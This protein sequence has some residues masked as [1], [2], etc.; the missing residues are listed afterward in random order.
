[1]SQAEDLLNSLT[2][3]SEEE[4]IIIGS[5]RAIKVP[6]SLKKIAVQFDNNVRTVTF[7]C[8]RY[9]DGRDLS[10]MV[11]CINYLLPNG[12]PGIYIVDAV[13]VDE[14]DNT[15]MHF[16]WIIE[17][18][19]TKVNGTLSFLVCAKKTKSD[20]TN[21]NHW[22]TE[23]NQEMTISKG[24]NCGEQIVDQNPD[25]I[26]HILLRLDTIES[27]PGLGFNATEAKENQVLMADGNGNWEWKDPETTE[28]ET[29]TIEEIL[30][31]TP[32]NK[33]QGTENS[34]K[35]AGINESGDI[36]PMIPAGV[37]YNEETKCLEYGEDPDAPLM[38]GIKLDGTLSK[39]GY[40]ADSKKV[41]DKFSEIE[42]K[43]TSK[44]TT[45]E[46]P[47]VGKI[48][49][50]KSVNKDGSFVCEWTD[51]ARELN[52]QIN[53]ESIVKDGI[54]EIPFAG[55]DNPGVTSIWAGYGLDL[56]SKKLL[57]A[58]I[59]EEMIRNRDS[60]SLEAV[61]LANLDYAVK[62]AMT[63]GKGDP[64]TAD[65]QAAA[66]E[67]ID[68]PSQH[69]VYIADI[70]DSASSDGM[71]KVDAVEGRVLKGLTL[72]GKSVQVTTT[73]KNLLY[74]CDTYFKNG[75][76]GD[77]S[78]M[79][80]YSLSTNPLMLKQRL[81]PGIYTISAYSSGVFTAYISTAPY[82][83]G[84]YK[85]VAASN[86]KAGDTYRGLKRYY[87]TFTIEEDT[88]YDIIGFYCENYT[89]C[90]GGMIERGSVATDYETYTGTQSSPSVEYPQSINDIVL[91]N[92]HL[93]MCGKNLINYIPNKTEYT[94]FR[95]L[96][97]GTV[98][99]LSLVIESTKSGKFA[100]YMHDKNDIFLGTVFAFDIKAGKNRYEYTNVCVGGE[101]ILRYY[102][103][104]INRVGGTLYDVQLEIDDKGT[105]FEPYKE[106][107]IT[108]DIN[109]R[110]S[111]IPVQTGGNYI[112]ADGQEWI[113]N[114]VDLESGKY[115]QNV[116]TIDLS[117][118]KW[119]KDDTY[120]SS[121]ITL[122]NFK[123]ENN[124]AILPFACWNYNYG[125]D[126]FFIDV[127][128]TIYFGA[129]FS[130]RFSTAEMFVT[131]LQDHDS[132]MYYQLAETIE[133]DITSTEIQGY[134]KLATYDGTTIIE[135]DANIH[136]KVSYAADPK[137]YIDK[138]FAELSAAI[139]ASASEAE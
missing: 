35:I 46:N 19:V 54:A 126:C 44:I 6:D 77:L 58:Q 101:A 42:T 98:V 87:G 23:L 118:L 69:D 79:W 14:N 22:N 110:F 114:Y 105:V 112:D 84:K 90:Y 52:V 85:T 72:Y 135:N 15:L 76:N 27:K 2:A 123:C 74:G 64:W 37:S 13:K 28:V 83:I 100:F 12:D 108:I 129:E 131:Y 25:V 61:N 57:L 115:I 139:V 31:Y 86:I 5:D 80:G 40:A 32:L 36:I 16:D 82:E 73:G 134:Q 128:G 97:K 21:E 48:L 107:T 81:E 127:N 88:S 103:I 94:L 95:E 24:L 63:D 104:D 138:K 38:Q 51:A 119:R 121:E 4:H 89:Y 96:S 66:R 132:T 78:Y 43:V 106:N 18:Y 30:G 8:P 117:T 109:E 9:S 56:I 49:K 111:G 91:E 124:R 136:M 60:K 113:S 68:A 67:R 20:G 130:K 62:A 75:K 26:A 47:I 10:T 133:R 11:I 92:M 55:F 137:S 50:V 17:E 71:V 102:P 3:D 29:G 53:G 33:N 41:G 39:S 99:T 65:E 59:T 34:G 45:P 122:Q 120:I 125:G 1:M 70:I 116:N 7:D 93:R